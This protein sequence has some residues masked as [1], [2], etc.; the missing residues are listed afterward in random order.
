M[1][2]RGKDSI[3]LTL[4]FATRSPVPGNC[5]TAVARRAPAPDSLRQ[6]L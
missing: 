1:R 5:T 2:L 6:T 4:L 3:P